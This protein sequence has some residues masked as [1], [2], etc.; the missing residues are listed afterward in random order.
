V[1]DS[2]EFTAKKTRTCIQ[3]DAIHAKH[4]QLGTPI[5]TVGALKL[6]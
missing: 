4:I 1:D 3:K 6:L 2:L 5:Y